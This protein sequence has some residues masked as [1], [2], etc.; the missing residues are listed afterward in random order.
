MRATTK[1]TFLSQ[2]RHPS[3]VAVLTI[4]TVCLALAGDDKQAFADPPGPPEAPQIIGFDTFEQFPG[5]WEVSGQ[6]LNHDG[7]NTVVDFGD[8]LLGQQ[9]TCDENGFFIHI[10]SA[11]GGETVSAQASCNS[12]SSNIV[13]TTCN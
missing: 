5:E 2:L 1:L 6:V 7:T 3:L 12:Q 9:T 13:T 8:Y 11:T 10:F 4:L